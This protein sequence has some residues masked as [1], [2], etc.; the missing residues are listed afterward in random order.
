MNTAA[1][2]MLCF[3]V[4]VPIMYCEHLACLTNNNI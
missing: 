4:V 3:W 2:V 1:S